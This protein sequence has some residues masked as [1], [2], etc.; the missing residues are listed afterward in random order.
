M[1]FISE[2]TT[3]IH[4]VKAADNSF[5]DAPSRVIFN[6][7]MPPA[8]D[9]S[10]LA[11]AQ[12]TDSELEV[13]R[14]SSRHLIFHELPLPEGGVSVICEMS[15]GAPRPLVPLEFR[16]QISGALHNLSHPGMG[17]TQNLLTERF[18]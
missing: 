8:I 4:H 3:D 10:A 18:T 11:L 13:L 1:A 9:Y 5:A 14:T 15:T 2:F 17:A 6:T 16:R 12:R 7:A